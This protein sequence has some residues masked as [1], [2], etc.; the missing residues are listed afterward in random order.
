MYKFVYSINYANERVVKI[1]DSNL[2]LS[3]VKVELKEKKN[4][5]DNAS[6]LFKINRKKTNSRYPSGSRPAFACRPA[7]R[8]RQNHVFFV[9]FQTFFVDFSREITEKALK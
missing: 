4:T 3:K 8:S 7:L 5:L 6:L 1:A 2:M 9:H